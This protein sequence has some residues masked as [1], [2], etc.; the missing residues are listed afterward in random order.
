MRF[1]TSAGSISKS[2]TLI[3]C[4]WCIG[5]LFLVTNQAQAGTYYFHNDHL[6]T[7]QTVTDNT[8]QVVWKGEYDPFGEVTETVAL[9]EQNIRFPGQ[10]FDQ[11]TGLYYNY[12]RTYNPETGRYVESDPIGLAGGLSTYGYVGGNP[13]LFVDLFGLEITGKWITSPHVGNIKLFKPKNISI[14]LDHISAT[15]PTSGEINYEILCMDDSC[16]KEKTWTL[17]DTQT[18]IYDVNIKQNFPKSINPC[19]LIPD[20][21]RR[22]ACSVARAISKGSEKVNRKAFDHF[23]TAANLLVRALNPTNICR[24]LGIPNSAK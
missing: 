4:V 12:F 10:Y 18:F 8:Q 5:L 13:L 2:K 11:E 24:L 9:V 21:S 17:S 23:K 19:L 22:T 20:K 7:P 6:G 14:G 16:G 1:S 15:V 3:M